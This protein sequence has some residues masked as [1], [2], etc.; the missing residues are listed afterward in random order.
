MLLNSPRPMNMPTS[1]PGFWGNYGKYI[2]P[3]VGAGLSGGLQ[4]YAAQQQQ[5]Q[6][7]PQFQNSIQPQQQQPTAPSSALPQNGPM[8]AAQA[9]QSDPRLTGLLEQLSMHKVNSMMQN[10]GQAQSYPEQLQQQAAG[11]ANAQISPDEGPPEYSSSGPQFAFDQFL[12]AGG[13]QYNP[14]SAL[15]DLGSQSNYGS[16]QNKSWQRQLGNQVGGL[17]SAAA[18]A[19]GVLG[20]GPLGAGLSSAF[21][22]GLQQL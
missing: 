4:A 12:G 16:G 21:G 6:Q 14:F 17:F 5:Q 2:I 19:I 8:Q 3:T 15:A 11:V 18:P 13:S 1:T 22:Y 20:G 10:M 9:Q 7:F